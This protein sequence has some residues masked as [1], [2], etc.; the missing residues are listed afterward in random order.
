MVWTKQCFCGSFILGKEFQGKTIKVSIANRRPMGNDMG[1]GGFGGR[2]IERRNHLVLSILS[3][4]YPPE[5]S[6][7]YFGLAFA[8]PPPV[9]RFSTLT[10]SGK[11]H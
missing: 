7:G 4:L 5:S 9:E 8:T 6:R 1:R 11:L 3:Y 2:G 10:L